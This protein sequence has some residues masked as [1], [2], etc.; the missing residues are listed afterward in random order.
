MR[1][2]VRQAYHIGDRARIEWAGR[3]I[4]GTTDL[5]ECAHQLLRGMSGLDEDGG[6]LVQH[7]LR[8]GAGRQP[9]A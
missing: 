1:Y 8:V 6:A 5:T 3:L 7:L 9:R 4:Q 2:D